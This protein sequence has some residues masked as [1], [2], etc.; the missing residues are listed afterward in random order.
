[1][2]RHP[3]LAFL[4]ACGALGLAGFSFGVAS[5]LSWFP[6]ASG[7]VGVLWTLPVISLAAL[8]WSRFMPW[9][10]PPGLITG[11]V[12]LGAIGPWLAW[13]MPESKFLPDL[14]V[15]TCFPPGFERES[16]AR[17]HPEMSPTEVEA[18]TGAP[19]IRRPPM[20]WG[21]RLPGDPDLV[22]VYSTDNCGP[23]GDYAWRSYQVGFRE[24]VVVAVSR[25]WRYD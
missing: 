25:A 1:M 12:L 24:G 3:R 15:D 6:V 23:T 5:A 22:W 14:Y 8:A 7:L 4:V 9:S 13:H 10:P 16:F 2:T 18:I 21:Y 20:T 17:L 11:L 19:R